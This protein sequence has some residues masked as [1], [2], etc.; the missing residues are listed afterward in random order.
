V[1]VHPNE[2]GGL[3]EVATRTVR[4]D[5][6][7][8][9]NRLTLD[10]FGLT[11]GHE[12]ELLIRRGD[13]EFAGIPAFTWEKRDARK[14]HPAKL[15]IA[16]VLRELEL[17]RHTV[18]GSEQQ[19]RNE[20]L[21]L[22]TNRWVYVFARKAE[23]GG[24]AWLDGEYWF[25][26]NGRP[27]RVNLRT[28]KA[29]DDRE[30][31]TGADDHIE[32]PARLEGDSLRVFIGASPFQLNWQRIGELEK[33]PSVRCYDI[34]TNS[35]MGTIWIPQR[36]EDHKE[37]LEVTD[38][39][40]VNLEGIEQDTLLVGVRDLL[41]QACVRNKEYRNALNHF[42]EVRF[43]TTVKDDG[44]GNISLEN[45][46]QQ[47]R[48]QL[49]QMTAGLVIHALTG[50]SDGAPMN[51]ALMRKCLRNEGADFKGWLSQK[52]HAHTQAYVKVHS[53]AQKVASYLQDAGWEGVEGDVAARAGDR[54][55]AATA[56]DYLFNSIA[57]LDELD[58]G[59]D[60]MVKHF[61]GKHPVLNEETGILATGKAAH[62][63]VGPYV[64]TINVVAKVYA[65]TP[66]IDAERK[67]AVVFRL[68]RNGL[69]AKLNVIQES[70]NRKEYLEELD[71]AL[72]G[73]TVSFE[74]FEIDPTSV[75]HMRDVD[76][77]ELLADSFGVVLDGLSTSLFFRTY[78][79]DRQSLRAEDYYDASKS[80]SAVLI[81]FG[82]LKYFRPFGSD[83]EEWRFRPRKRR[84]WTEFT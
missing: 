81:Y 16:A 49:E 30:A 45:S 33:D 67:K 11:P 35:T 6:V 64:K 47:S 7:A 56:F 15:S 72:H 22:L 63:N 57:R 77:F 62:K 46:E 74:R 53:E 23:E 68:V 19:I 48:S 75:G 12:Y 76:D 78:L 21:K 2:N 55:G 50:G 54:E 42:T 8:G 38:T 39:A 58:S 10:F 70:F 82:K 80:A 43:D 9:D 31:N 51:D 25:D 28:Q 20:R 84:S 4:D 61:Q 52:M 59:R 24:S 83:N 36:L 32:I 29:V 44:K 3:D 27:H 79:S 60:I 69:D 13:D 65:A 71:D 18:L 34:G 17:H 41:S 73:R 5:A 66:A 37:L 40:D 14:Y 26:E 1:L